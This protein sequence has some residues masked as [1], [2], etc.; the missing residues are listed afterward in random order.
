MSAKHPCGGSI[1]PQVS[2][3]PYCYNFP[4]DRKLL[5]KVVLLFLLVST[6]S[7]I[8]IYVQ[9]RIGF[10]R[11]QDVIKEV[12]FWGPAIYIF[13]QLL[14]H[15]AAPIQGTPLNIAAIAAFGKSAFLYMYIT[16]VISSFTNFW[17]ARKLGRD[18]VV[19]L[20]GKDGMA[21]IDH[22]AE[23][24]GVKALIILRFFQGFIT[25]FVSYAAGLTKMKF[26]TYY[27][28]SLVV[29]I[30]WLMVMLLIFNKVSAQK[31]FFWSLAIG[32][33]FFVIPPTYYYL[34]HKFFEERIVHKK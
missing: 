9:N 25:D 30:P 32:A 16:H 34:K 11:I 33:V 14:T 19:R 13:L 26:S 1:P 4:M 17:I 7:G 8:L 5:R 22:D 21:N 23:H 12:G 6:V 24:E 10:D 20:V 18:I 3:N 2:K 31:I 29:P 27:L 15:I 28:I